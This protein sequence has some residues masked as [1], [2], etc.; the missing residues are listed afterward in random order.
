[1]TKET[2]LDSN[3]SLPFL[4]HYRSCPTFVF[5]TAATGLFTS[6]F[7]HSILFPL[8][9]FIVAR[10]RHL[11]NTSN[12][13]LTSRDT[14]L[15]VALYAVGL[16]VGSPLFG[17]LGDKIKQRRIP[18]LLGTGAS[19][20]ANILFMFSL[21]YP[22]LLI[23]R[24]MQGVSNACVWTMCLCLIADN[25]PKEQLGSQMGKL[26]GFY[27]LGMM[28][29]LPAGGVLYSKL[30]YEA[31]FIAS[32]ILCGIDFFMRLVVIEK[33]D[34]TVN[35]E[36][37]DTA[38]EVTSKKRV[39]WLKLLKQK[40]L[41]VSLMLSTIV[42]TVMS[43]FEPTLSMRL[44]QEWGF[45]P[46]GCSLILLAY[47]IPSIAA[48]WVWGKMCDKMGTKLVAILALFFATPSCIVIGVPNHLT[49]S[50]WLIIPGL[51]FGGITIAGC[52]AP[53][54]PEIAKVVDAENDESSTSDGIAK[55]YSLFNAA[56]GIG[57]RL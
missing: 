41:I 44:V 29:G 26:V 32:V 42:A 8:A 1:M 5:L 7:I 14:G 15:L 52:Q 56:Y 35:T 21:N 11:D 38:K 2:H 30:G 40:R 18:M 48:S 33:T 36:S 25:W 57:T 53:V 37:E 10:V 51:I 27:P 4:H 49:G 34:G 50:F 6:T 13:E 16:L 3:K 54:F 55:S 39:T 20:S 23:A 43:A 46:A 9:P 28:V 47:M 45:D 12:I 19:I 24:L 17:W 31:P 22:M